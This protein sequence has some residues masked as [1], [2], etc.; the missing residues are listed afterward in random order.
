MTR[1]KRNDQNGKFEGTPSAWGT[2]G[3]DSYDPDPVF[4]GPVDPPD[5]VVCEGCAESWLIYR[6][7]D[8]KFEAQLRDA[9]DDP[10]VW[11]CWPVEPELGDQC[12]SC[13]EGGFYTVWTED[14]WTTPGFVL[15]GA[16]TT[17]PAHTDG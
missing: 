12:D 16:G 7:E 3:P 9:D 6:T 11:E 14:G 2:D 10:V 13:E 8:G 17:R 15:P 4:G 5:R 1:L